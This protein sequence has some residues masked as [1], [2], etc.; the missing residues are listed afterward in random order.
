VLSLNPRDADWLASRKVS[1][2]TI[3]A[4]EGVPLVLAGDDDKNTVYANLRDAERIFARYMITELDWVADSLNGW[5]VPDFDTSPPG[6]RRL[7]IGFDYSGIEALQ[8]PLEDRQRVALQEVER[9]VRGRREYRR[10]FR[11]GDPDSMPED[12][13]DYVELKNLLPIGEDAP[14]PATQ[15]N[16]DQR[17]AVTD[18]TATGDLG[19]DANRAA[20][21]LRAIGRTLY[22]QPAVRAWI[23]DP[24]KPLSTVTLLGQSLEEPIRQH[25][26]A[27]LRRRASA[28][29]IASS[30][31][32][33]V[34]A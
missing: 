19:S 21:E 9:G 10:T 7:V 11:V 29:Q 8:A 5:L 2:M 20:D 34:P 15:P 4:V 33:G 27:G 13:P 32:E 28:E 3:C 26:E 24:G 23:A 12:V 25:I 30:L 17:G 14:P 31:S 18:P 1:R 22:R 16:P 6:K